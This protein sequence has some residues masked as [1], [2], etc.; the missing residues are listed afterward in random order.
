MIPQMEI[1]VFM[2]E[3]MAR[4]VDLVKRRGRRGL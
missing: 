2:S 4:V 1:A 3:V